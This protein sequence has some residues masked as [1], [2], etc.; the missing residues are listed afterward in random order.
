MRLPVSDEE[1]VFKVGD[2]VR[3]NSGGHLRTI[4]SFDENT[5][6]CVWSVK[7]DARSKSYPAQALE[8]ADAPSDPMELILAR[9]GHPREETVLFEV[10]NVVAFK[11]GG[12]LMTVIFINDNFLTCAWSVRDA[13]KSKSFPTEALKI[14]AEPFDLEKVTLRVMELREERRRLSDPLGGGKALANVSGIAPCSAARNGAAGAR[15]GVR[16]RA[17]AAPASPSVSQCGD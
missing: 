11:S 8:K 6:T 10:G 17:V 16:A 1:T 2:V 7:G 4:I 3:L 13:D 12:H 15:A 5:V 9:A 14:A